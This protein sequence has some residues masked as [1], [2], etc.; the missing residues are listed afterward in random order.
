MSKKKLKILVLNYEFPPLGGGAGNATYY[1]LKEFAKLDDIYVDLVTSSASEFEHQKFSQN[2]NIYKLNI[3][4]KGN[5]HYQSNKDIIIYTIK[6]YFFTRKLLHQKKYNLVH[7]FFGIPCGFIGYLFRKKIP[8]IISIRGSDVPG[9]NERFSDLYKVLSPL[10]KKVWKNSKAVIANSRDLKKLAL[11][12][13][14]NQ[15]IDIIYNGIDV[16]EFKAR[17]K[18]NNNSFNVLCVTR[19]IKRK[20]IKY[21]VL[22]LPKVIK[23][24][25]DLNLKLTIIGEGNL[26][27]DLEDLVKDKNLNR[28]IYFKGLIEHSQ[29]PLY[30]NRADVFILPS[31]NEGMSNAVLEAISSG[32]PIITTDTG[33]T[34]ELVKENGFIVPKKNS[35]KISEALI[36][37]IED[38]DLCLEM[39]EKSREIAEKLGWD[40]VA[41]QYLEIYKNYKNNES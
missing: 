11:I 39:G 22:A 20:G 34:S 27:K 40:K 8:Y 26:K 28:F 13:S 6:S 4:K 15:K 32:L 5:I 12:T 2:I 36:K 19:L 29:L 14:P 33:G 37:L 16:G 35:E 41:E 3:G 31:L 9:Y 30:Y 21:L 7:A 25:P 24:Y 18:K 10:I 23:K 38:K 1:L 17:N